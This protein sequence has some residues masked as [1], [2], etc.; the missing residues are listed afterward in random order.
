MKERVIHLTCSKTG[1]LR[2]GDAEA[3]E[4]ISMRAKR[5]STPVTAKHFTNKH[6]SDA[7]PIGLSRKKRSEQ[8]RF[9]FFVDTCT[10]IRYF[11]SARSNCFHTN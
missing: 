7:L 9:G 6:Q 3:S 4:A 11:D 5:K 1:R 10:I 2:K 8:L